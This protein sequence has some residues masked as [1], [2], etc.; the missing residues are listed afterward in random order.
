MTRSISIGWR[1]WLVIIQVAALLFLTPMSGYSET[2]QINETSGLSES[3][4]FTI[5]F[6]KATAGRTDHALVAKMFHEYRGFFMPAM[7][8]TELVNSLQGRA[9][10]YFPLAQL[11]T[12]S[13]YAASIGKLISSDQ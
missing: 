11:K 6:K 10:P 13:V 9:V 4:R 8:V 7:D 5:D 2:K 1:T 12:E 3:E